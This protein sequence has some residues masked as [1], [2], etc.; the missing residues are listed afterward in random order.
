MFS[1]VSTALYRG[2]PCHS[3]D[4]NARAVLSLWHTVLMSAAGV[5]ARVRAEMTEEIKTVARRHLASEGANLSLRAVARDLGMASSAVYR[6]FASRDDLLTALI[7]DAYESVGVAAERALEGVSGHT[8]RLVAVGLAVREWALAEPYQWALIYG[9]PVPGYRAPQDT[10]GP[11]TRVI[12][13][14]VS[15]VQDAFAAGAVTV[16]PPISGRYAEEL[17]A[18]AAQFGPEIPAQLV[19]TTFGAFVHLCGA[20]SAE[21]F[22]QLDTSVDDDRGGFLEFQ[23]RGAAQL[24]GLTS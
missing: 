10:I 3:R 14:I 24:I 17:S 15:I 9:S 11:A 20:V 21:L 22:G 7:I 23:M 4:R 18:V 8:D 16:G 13:L 1:F 19:G 2:Q 12:L 5:R 6:Y